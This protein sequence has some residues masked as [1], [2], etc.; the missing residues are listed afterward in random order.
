M[1]CSSSRKEERSIS[2]TPNSVS[3]EPEGANNSASSSTPD[4]WSGCVVLL[5]MLWWVVLEIP[6]DEGL[7]MEEAFLF[8][9]FFLVGD[10]TVFVCMTFL[11]LGEEPN[12][13]LLLPFS[14]E[15]SERAV[16]LPNAIESWLCC[17]VEGVVVVV[18]VGCVGVWGRTE[19][20]RL[21]SGEIGARS[22][23]LVVAKEGGRESGKNVVKDFAS[24]GDGTDEDVED[25]GETAELCCARSAALGRGKI[26]VSLFI[27]GGGGINPSCEQLACLRL[28]FL[29]PFEA[30]L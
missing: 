3:S 1:N 25:G 18:V 12:L 4:T 20:G 13:R 27:R 23:A 16:L 5:S 30:F 29:V 9:S 11:R 2:S 17:S 22:F 21:A 28:R 24:G 10:T 19:G 26:C 14:G 6:P 7:R 15:D 8:R